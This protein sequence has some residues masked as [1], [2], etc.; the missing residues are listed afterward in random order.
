MVEGQKKSEPSEYSSIHVATKAEMDSANYSK[1]LVDLNEDRKQA[2]IDFYNSI[3]NS[4]IKT[5]L[6]VA[7]PQTA[8]APTNVAN[9][10]PSTSSA[11]I[12]SLRPALTTHH[13]F[14]S[15][16]LPPCTIYIRLF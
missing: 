7:S 13:C 6:A 4:G 16:I 5:A 8:F 14:S 12:N 15:L 11:T 9:A 1:K 10:S 3:L 2:K